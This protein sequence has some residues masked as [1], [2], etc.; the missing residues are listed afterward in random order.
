MCNTGTP[1]DSTS[2]TPFV[3]HPKKCSKPN[4]FIKKN[5]YNKGQVF[6]FTNI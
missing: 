6:L 1:K 4:K 3:Y 2:V 5:P